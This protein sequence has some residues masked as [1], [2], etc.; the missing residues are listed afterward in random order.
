MSHLT[1]KDVSR[2]AGVSVALSSAVLNRANSRIRASRE[3]ARQIREVADRL[4]YIP[5]SNARGLKMS[6]SFLI[7]VVAYAIDTSFV[8]AILE[9]CEDFFL[10]N[11]Y[12]MLLATYKD[13]EKLTVHLETFRRR[14]IDGLI[15]IPGQGRGLPE[16]LQAFTEIPK[17]F[18]GAGFHLPNS[19]SVLTDIT[20]IARI[21]VTEFVK[22]RH[23]VIAYLHNNGTGKIEAWRNSLIQAGLNP[24]PELEVYTKNWFDE[25]Y[26]R[27][28]KLLTEN[29]LVTALFADS[30]TVGAAA[31]RVAHEMKR[32][33]AVIGVDDSPYC[34]MLT[35]ELASIAVPKREH[36]SIAAQQLVLLLDGKEA[37]NIILQPEFR[38]RASVDS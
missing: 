21:A 26:V 1:L 11:D 37:Q 19:V 20:A 31:I 32:K 3:T 24:M 10:N 29:P 23:R 7:G 5:N 22:R 25:G 35:P 28:H 2:E 33:L 13:L 38:C 17:V 14:S 8:P 18:V 30:D 36:G 6:R 4:G 15:I 34:R 9:G 27:V 12:G 16:R